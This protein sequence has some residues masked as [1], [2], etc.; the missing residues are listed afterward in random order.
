M[1]NPIIDHECCSHSLEIAI[2]EGKKILIFLIKT[3]DVV[4]DT[5]GE[6]PDVASV[7]LLSCEAS[8]LIDTGQE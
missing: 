7:K 3:L 6:I 8:V 4:G 5:L 2:V 1:G